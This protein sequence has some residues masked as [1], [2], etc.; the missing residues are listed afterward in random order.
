[1]G[2]RGL[3]VAAVVLVARGILIARDAVADRGFVLLTV[4]AL[5]CAAEPRPVV[6]NQVAPVG[7]EPAPATPDL[8]PDDALPKS[9]PHRPRET[10]EWVYCRDYAGNRHPVKLADRMSEAEARSQGSYGRGKFDES[11]RLL[12]YEHWPRGKLGLAFRYEYDAS[13]ALTRATG[14]L[15]GQEPREIPL[16]TTFPSPGDPIPSVSPDDDFPTFPIARGIDA[17]LLTAPV[18]RATAALC[19]EVGARAETQEPD[20]IFA[21]AGEV[22]DAAGRWKELRSVD[23]LRRETDRDPTISSANVWQT[24]AGATYITL[25]E[26]TPS[27]DW[28]QFLSY[29]YRPD[30][31]LAKV[32]ALLKTFYAV[33]NPI[34]RTR[35]VYLDPHGVRVAERIGVKDLATGQSLT[36]AN[37]QEA[38][39]TIPARIEALPFGRLLLQAGRRR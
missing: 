30:R 4:L 16:D 2:A 28:A 10:T 23:E 9:D 35:E 34:S 20:R 36:R 11:G 22:K 27:G 15:P 33:P 6:N 31:S 39:V 14:H 18:P 7:A 5:G 29:C 21:A 26:D 13:G 1:M 38:D 12:V 8:E 25:S 19:D 32:V 3:V 24:A 17:R 37:Y